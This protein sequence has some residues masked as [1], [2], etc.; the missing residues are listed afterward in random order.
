MI[1]WLNKV[2]RYLATLMVVGFSLIAIQHRVNNERMHH[3]CREI[4]KL[5]GG[6]EEI[7]EKQLEIIRD[8]KGE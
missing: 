4:H 2:D 8:I 6:Q 7:K 5:E 1:K 3:M